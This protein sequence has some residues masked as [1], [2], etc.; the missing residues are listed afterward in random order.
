MKIDKMLLTAISSL[1]FFI[2][3]N[4]GLLEVVGLT[5]ESYEELTLLIFSVLSLAGYFNNPKKER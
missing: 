5:K 3:K 2:L 4:Y 1:I